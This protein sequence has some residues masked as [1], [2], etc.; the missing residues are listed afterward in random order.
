MKT[1]QV[2]LGARSRAGRTRTGA[3]GMRTKL[4]QAERTALSDGRMIDAAVKLVSARGTHNTTL[5]E[6]GEMA[7]YSRGLAS[8]RF[9]SK[10]ALFGEL[11]TQFNRRWK[12]ESTSAVGD[13]RGLHALLV[14]NETLVDFFHHESDQI[15]A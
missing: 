7:G 9:G 1:G 8:S 3:K 6:I 15:R 11:L 2:E 5:K 13:H 14:A 10:E 12:Q 4:T